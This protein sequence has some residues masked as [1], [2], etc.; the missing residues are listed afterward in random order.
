MIKVLVSSCLI[1]E[2]VRYHGGDARCV[3]EILDRWLAEGRLVPFCPETAAGLPVPREAAEIAGDGGAAVLRGD[4]FVGDRTGS[5]LTAAFVK[6]ARS[7]LE[8]AVAHGARLAVLKDGSPSCGTSY[9]H[10]GSFRGQRGPGQGVTAAMLS[11]AGIR[12]FNEHQLEEAAAYLEALE[13]GAPLRGSHE[14]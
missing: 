3:N 2:P 11:S 13:R 12:L 14:D 9:I 7:T 4:A 6:G 8:T 5:D 10:D 1:G